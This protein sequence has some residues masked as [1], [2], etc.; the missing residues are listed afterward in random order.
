MNVEKTIN[1]GV[2]IKPCIKGVGINY[3]KDNKTIGLIILE[4]DWDRH[5]I[6]INDPRKMRWEFDPSK[7]SKEQVSK[8]VVHLIDY[9]RRYLED[10]G[11]S[12]MVFYWVRPELD[13]EEVN[14]VLITGQLVA[15]QQVVSGDFV[16][17]AP[18]A[19][20]EEEI[21]EIIS[22]IGVG[23]ERGTR[24]KHSQVMGVLYN[25]VAEMVKDT[26]GEEVSLEVLIGNPIVRMDYT[27]KSENWTNL[28]NVDPLFYKLSIKYGDKEV[29]IEP[30]RESSRT[31][32]RKVAEFIEIANGKKE[33]LKAE[34]KVEYLP[35]A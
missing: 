25:L 4:I 16:E 35:K 14:E 26:T 9:L 30:L 10:T 23:K 15:P 18:P 29:N 24:I 11:A 3:T 32:A 7:S 34:V 28:I 5:I 12:T 1:R 33:G 19:A 8:A 22:D 13:N 31:I 21:E 20:E 27:A 17:G 2:V 6:Y